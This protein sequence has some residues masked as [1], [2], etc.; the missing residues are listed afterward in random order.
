MNFTVEMSDSCFRDQSGASTVQTE[1]T[2]TNKNK[3]N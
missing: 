1:F 3:Q 2:N